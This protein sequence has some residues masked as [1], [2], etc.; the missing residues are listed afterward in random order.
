MIYQISDGLYE[1]L[2]KWG[3]YFL[4]IL[5]VFEMILNIKLTVNIVNRIYRLS[6]RIDYVEDEA[7]IK[8]NAIKGISQIAS[9]MAHR[10]GLTKQTAYIKK[11]SATERH[12]Y[13]IARYQRTTAGGKDVFHFVLVDIDDNV[14][15]DPWSMGGSKTVRE[16]RLSG[17]RYLWGELL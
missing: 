5:R 9:S 15:Y 10:E 6:R 7:Y 2:K 14:I 17:H 11:V 1:D 12:N 8:Q 4:C 13:F 16:G 3:C